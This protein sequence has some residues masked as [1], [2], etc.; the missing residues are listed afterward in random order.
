MRWSNNVFGLER[1]A[2]AFT[3]FVSATDGDRSVRQKPDGRLNLSDGRRRM[4]GVH[5]QA[6][7]SAPLT[8]INDLH[9]TSRRMTTIIRSIAPHRFCM[10]ILQTALCS[11]TDLTQCIVIIAI[12][13]V[14]V[15]SPYRVLACTPARR[16]T[17]HMRR[18][19]VGGKSCIKKT[20]FKSYFKLHT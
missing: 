9:S 17:V 12:T 13:A 20:H 1:A 15:E 2:T 6:S 14:F 11:V 5:G 4:N 10:W 8:S 7:T 19:R 3:V 18:S 16:E